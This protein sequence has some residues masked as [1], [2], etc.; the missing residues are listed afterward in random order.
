MAW[1]QEGSLLDKLIK[2]IDKWAGNN[3]QENK[4]Y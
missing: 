4:K 1:Y 2:S 3:P